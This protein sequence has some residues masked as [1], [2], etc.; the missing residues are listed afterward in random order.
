MIIQLFG[1]ELNGQKI[2]I[3]KDELFLG[4]IEIPKRIPKR[5][6]GSLSQDNRHI[7]SKRCIMT[8]NSF[9]S[10]WVAK[11][12]NERKTLEMLVDCYFK[13]N[14]LLDM[15]KKNEDTM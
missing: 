11:G 1:G 5:D 2:E 10:V 12:L 4:H 13:H 7:Y 6:H 9:L 3:T 14:G 8:C 15:G